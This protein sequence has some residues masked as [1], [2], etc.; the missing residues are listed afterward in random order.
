MSGSSP[1]YDDPELAAAY[2]RVSAANVANAAYERPAVRAL[3]GGVRGLD[4]LDAG[5]AAGEHSAWL[6]EHGARVVALDASETMVGLARER[7]GESARVLHADLA[8]RL[9]LADA[10]FDVVLSSLTLHYL[11][12][13]VPPL[14]EF[15]RVLRPGGRLVVSTHHP[16]MTAAGVD[17]YHAVAPVEEG[18]NGFADQPVLV[19]FYHRPL[20]R[21]VSDVLNAGFTLRGLHEPQ[22]TPDADE[23]DPKL[24]ARFRREPGFLIVHAEAARR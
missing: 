8:Q 19:R 12:D 4:V 14:R 18:W 15:A 10:S 1:L 13:W 22:P 21:I 7:L 5:C 17:D 9:P 11:E 16:Y 2:A 24:A 3:I 20:Q 6:V 23:R